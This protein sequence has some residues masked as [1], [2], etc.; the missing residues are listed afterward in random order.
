VIRPLARHW[1]ALANSGLAVVIAL[2]ILAPLLLRAGR[3]ELADL[4]YA[5]Y[6]LTCHEWAFRSLF[7]FGPQ[8]TYSAAELQSHGVSAV[9]DFRGSPE[10]GYKLAF[11]VRNLAIYAAGLA[12]GLAYAAR[13]GWL[14]PL[15]VRAYIV[16]SAPMAVDGLTQLFGW[17]ESSWQ[18]RVATGGLFGL[19][20][21]WLL[22][23]RIDRLA[24][25]LEPLAERGL[26]TA[27]AER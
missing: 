5:G 23:P 15:S 17:R 6:M 22:F 7:L 20:S 21:V 19:A 8:V 11:C 16:L 18:L 14:P 2:T 27:G 10:L 9:F 24:A 4:I 25:E 1:L 12:G 26:Q 3:D 13:R